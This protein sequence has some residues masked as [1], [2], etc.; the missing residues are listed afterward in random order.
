MESTV[1]IEELLQVVAKSPQWPNRPYLAEGMTFKQVYDQADCIKAALISSG[2]TRYPVC[3]C[4]EN[5]GHMA[6]A[7]LAA[8][9]GGPALL[10]PYAFSAQILSDARRNVH[11]SHALVP[12]QGRLPDEVT[13]I[14]IPEPGTEPLAVQS[15]PNRLLEPDATWAYLFTGGSTGSPRIWSKS[16]RNL[17]MEAANLA[18]A[19]QIEKDD[20]ILATV[21][22]NHIY[23]LLYSVLLPLVSGASVSVRTPSFPHEIVQA[24]DETRASVFVSIP[25][26]YRALQAIKIP[27]HCIHR[28]FS[29]GGALSQA[30]DHAFF[31]STGI[32]V[33]EIYGSTE[34]GGIAY[35]QRGA[36]QKTLRPFSYVD[37][38]LDGE[39]LD[40]RSEFLSDELH[41]DEHGYFSTT[42]RVAPAGRDGFEI[43]GRSDGVVKVG[44]KRVDLSNIRQV[45]LDIDGVEDAY[46]FSVPVTS[47]RENE[48]IGIVAGKVDPDAISKGIKEALPLY[49]LPRRLK[50]VDRIPMSAT[51][52]YNRPAIEKIFNLGPDN[53]D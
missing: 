34:T 7:L 13:G 2:G 42:D 44:G 30:D 9:T 29:S 18:K 28:A 45:I 47:G 48:I 52:K 11:F 41:M 23:G 25:A 12:G 33:T 3:L 4:L 43:L 24:I 5:R 37:V 38:R 26:H 14:P 6:A 36:G 31:Q 17:L 1:K 35:R 22:P 50:V 32:A 53:A 15:I 46:I 21:P 20:V 19:F 27:T 49:A 39:T 51:G 16:P 10:L 40:V 8:L